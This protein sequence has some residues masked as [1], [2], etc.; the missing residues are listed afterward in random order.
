MEV[1]VLCSGG[2]NSMTAL[3]AAHRVR[4]VL[5]FDYGATH[6]AR[7]IPF[8]AHRA[9]ALGFTP[10]VIDLPFIDHLCASDLLQ[11]GGD[12][13]DGHYADESMRR[14]VVPFRNGIRLSIAIGFAESVGAASLPDPTRYAEPPPPAAS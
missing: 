4:A 5:S 2:K 9:R 11:S 1:V 12:I 8:A 13:P 10:T 14:A 3:Y 7:E 6:N